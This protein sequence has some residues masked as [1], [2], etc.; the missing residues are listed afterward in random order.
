M[1]NAKPEVNEA[2]GT[3]RTLQKRE[4]RCGLRAVPALTLLWSPSARAERFYRAA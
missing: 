4:I 3:K 2:D 1:T